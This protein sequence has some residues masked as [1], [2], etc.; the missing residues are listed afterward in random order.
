MSKSV[1][2][3]AGEPS[4]DALGAS[5]M[6]GLKEQG[7]AEENLVGIGGDL[8]SAEGLESLLPMEDI[9]VMG[10]WE[11]AWH[12]PRL[13]RLIEGI[14]EEIE[15]RQ[16]DIVV[17]IDLPDFNF[18][19]AQRLKK[20]GTFKGKIIHYVAPTVWAWRPGRAKKVAS[21]LD[22]MMC[23]FPFEPDYFEK[24][25]LKAAYVGHPLIEIDKSAFDPETFRKERE[26]TEE[27]LCVGLF[28]GSRVRELN[29]LSKSFLETMDVLREQYPNLKLIVPT[30]PS[31]EFELMGCLDECEIETHVVV[32]QAQK[33]NAMA[34]CD[35]ALAVSG[36]VALELSYVETP[37]IIGYKAHP[38]TAIILK[39][40][41]KTPYAH[42][43]NIFLEE[44]AVPE[45]LQG[46]C[47]SNNLTRGLMRLIR[48]PEEKQ[49]QKDA[50]KKLEAQLRLESDEAPSQ[51]AARFVLG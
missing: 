42:L 30:L 29:L 26:I 17:G 48:Y 13:L 23:L 20:R 41:V 4:G 6:R 10:L 39:F 5:L 7:I 22:G 33:W 32:D 38:L 27:D 19:V 31:L 8:M 43:T 24:H 50:F 1:F 47:N 28:L 45:F 3:I 51:R 36:T 2:L 49:K 16:P 37:H 25:G 44:E 46:K 14:V 35:V 18:Q 21:F 11:V 40:L 9:C 15:L 12:L 34:A